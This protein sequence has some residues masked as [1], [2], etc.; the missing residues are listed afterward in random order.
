[1]DGMK[2][3]EE[4]WAR[5]PLACVVAGV[6]IVGA[7]LMGLRKVQSKVRRAAGTARVVGLFVTICLILILFVF[8][9]VDPLERWGWA[10]A[11]LPAIMVGQHAAFLRLVRMPFRVPSPG[12]GDTRAEPKERRDYWD[13]MAKEA[14]L[15]PIFAAARRNSDRYFSPSALAIRYGTPALAIALVGLVVFYLLFIENAKSLDP[16]IKAAKLG[17]SG[18]YVYVLLYLGQR[19]FRQDVTSGGAMWCAVMLALGPV[20]AWAISHFSHGDLLPGA[21]PDQ[22]EMGMQ[23]VYFAAG[24]APRHVASF[25]DETIRRVWVSPSNVTMAMPRTIPIT[26]VK[27]ITTGICERLSEEG[28]LDVHGLA[29]ADPLRLIRNTNF[30][31]RQILAWIDEAILIS[32][33]PDHWQ[34]LEKAGYT[35]AI[36]LTSLKIEPPAIA[37]PRITALAQHVKC[38]APILLGVVDRLAEDPQ[39]ALVRVLY[40]LIDRLDAESEIEPGKLIKPVPEGA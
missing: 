35:G 5:A 37:E 2:Q 29:N 33:L 26:Q 38:D 39:L 21:K 23:L 30:D 12:T 18:A 11:L 9:I 8:L 36:D 7:L 24:L 3:I 1:M 17:V 22:D 16:N 10:L 19:N 34:P 4:L 27:G 40:D 31:K 25:L 28:I 32:V 13:E 20:L 6:A 14:K 15:R